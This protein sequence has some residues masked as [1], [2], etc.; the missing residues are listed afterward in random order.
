MRDLVAF[1]RTDLVPLAGERWEVRV[2][3]SSEEEL[4]AVLHAAARWAA[5]CQLSETEV[6]VDDQRVDL[7]AV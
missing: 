2:E 7:P 4:D 3:D 6:L 5:D 1:A